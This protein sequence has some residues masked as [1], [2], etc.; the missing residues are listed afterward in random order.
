MRNAS[1]VQEVKVLTQQSD[2]VHASV[3]ESRK[4]LA[5]ARIEFAARSA[6]GAAQSNEL[7]EARLNLAT[8]R[9]ERARV[10]EVLQRL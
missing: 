6:E 8:V 9:T 2:G 5:S 1:A 7:A 4:L 10:C 3:E